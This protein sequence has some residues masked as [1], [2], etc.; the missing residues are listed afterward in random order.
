[1]YKTDKMKRVANDL[2]DFILNED[3]D[4]ITIGL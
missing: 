3:V 4:G 1:M 2:A